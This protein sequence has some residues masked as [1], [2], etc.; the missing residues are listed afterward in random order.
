MISSNPIIPPPPSKHSINWK[1]IISHFSHGVAS[2]ELHIKL[3]SQE[4]HQE[5]DFTGKWGLITGTPQAW[6]KNEI[7]FLESTHKVPH[8]LGTSEKAVTKRA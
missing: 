1:I 7:P 2:S 5:E 3:P 8:T 6:D 4:L